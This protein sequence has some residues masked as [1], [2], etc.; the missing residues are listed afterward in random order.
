MAQVDARIFD[1]SKSLILL[2]SCAKTQV[3]ARVRHLRRVNYIYISGAS[4]SRPTLGRGQ[5]G[6]A[7]PTV[8]QRAIRPP[9]RFTGRRPSQRHE[10]V[11]NGGS[12][13]GVAAAGRKTDQQFRD[14]QA[15]EIARAGNSE[16]DFAN[17]LE[18]I[19]RSGP[20]SDRTGGGHRD[21]WALGPGAAA[22]RRARTLGERI[23]PA[24]AARLTDRVGAK[25]RP[26]Q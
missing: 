26:T 1:N 4:T 21:G 9:V 5:E 25:E 2:A 13:R 22:R 16:K 19:G 15:D 23:V 14:G 8:Y 20:R 18:K 7:P 12:D 10:A 3:D 6:H 11:R 24:R 17:V